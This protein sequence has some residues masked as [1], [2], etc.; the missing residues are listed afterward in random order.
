MELVPFIWSLLGVLLIIS[1]FFIPGFVIFFFGAGA[2]LNGLLTTLLPVLR[3]QF[4]IQIIIW[5]AFSGVSLFGLRKYLSKV[6]KGRLLG[7]RDELEF[8]G[9]QVEVIKQIRPD[10]PGR[11]RFAGTTW[12]AISYDE[13]L[14][15]GEKVEILE[16]KNLTFVVTKSIIDAES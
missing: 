2:L 6:F 4:A 13:T 12:K 15:T 10:K 1:E 3:P 11:V 16:K 14:K 7:S 9:R 8:T 5:L